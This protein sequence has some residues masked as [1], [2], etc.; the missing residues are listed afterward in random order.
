MLG[1]TFLNKWGPLILSGFK[2]KMAG[3]QNSLQIKH[4]YLKKQRVFIKTII[5]IQQCP[6]QILQYP[7]RTLLIF[8][9]S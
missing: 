9:K 7:N 8:I 2:D 6:L 1:F 5:F 3:H 4:K